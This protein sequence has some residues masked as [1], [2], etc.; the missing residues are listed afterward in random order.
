V[1]IGTDGAGN[2]LVVDCR[3]GAEY[4]WLRDHDHGDRGV[5][6][7][8]YFTSL[9]DLLSRLVTSLRTGQPLE[10]HTRVGTDQLTPTVT[11]GTLTWD[12]PPISR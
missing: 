2:Y 3:P 12:V 4:G 9:D 10:Y 5:V 7:P 11:D 1:P 6:K 8:P